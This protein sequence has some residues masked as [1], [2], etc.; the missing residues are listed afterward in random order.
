M[1]P[2]P[3][4]SASQALDK[5]RSIQPPN[6]S[7]VLVQPDTRREIST[8]SGIPAAPR[9]QSS[10]SAPQIIDER[11]STPASLAKLAIERYEYNKYETLVLNEMRYDQYSQTRES[12]ASPTR[13][14]ERI[15]SAG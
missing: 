7:A 9:A 5:S 14:G 4:P 3:G 8:A 11:P 1:S 10:T 15:T 6:G 13:K 12:E 2:K